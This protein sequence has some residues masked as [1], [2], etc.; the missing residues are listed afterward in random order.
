M[1]TSLHTAAFIHANLYKDSVA[2]MR[3]AQSMLAM[4]GV[5]NATLQM[6]NPAN[7]DILREAGLLKSAVQ[8]AGP[9]DVMVVVQARTADGCDAAVTR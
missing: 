3:V 7:K 4:P 8:D 9:S 2:L 5:V 1:T 6:G